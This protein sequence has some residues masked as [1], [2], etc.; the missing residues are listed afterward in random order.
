M[1]FWV[2]VD[3]NLCSFMPQEDWVHP[4]RGGE[5]LLFVHTSGGSGSVQVEVAKNLCLF[6]PK[7]DWFSSKWRWQRTFVHSRFRRTGFYPSGGDKELLFIHAKEALGP[8][9]WT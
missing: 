4:G 1:S 7:E 8:Y 6:A 5:E 2:E 3:K 9:I